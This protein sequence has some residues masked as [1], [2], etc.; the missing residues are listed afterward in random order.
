[1][2]KKKQN[3]SPTDGMGFWH[4]FFIKTQHFRRLS[5]CYTALTLILQLTDAVLVQCL[6]QKFLV[7]GSSVVKCKMYLNVVLS[8][9]NLYISL[10]SLPSHFVN[11]L[12]M[13]IWGANG[14]L[15]FSLSQTSEGL[16]TSRLEASQ[17]LFYDRVRALLN[18]SIASNVE[19][20]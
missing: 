15:V 3:R 1:M 19:D 6:P 9:E 13:C 5:C 16:C 4:Q 7:N 11:F 10:S 8:L 2:I 12:K 14:G 17:P 18:S 20:A